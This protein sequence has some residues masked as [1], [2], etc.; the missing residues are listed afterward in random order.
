MFFLE[1]NRRLHRNFMDMIDQQNVLIKIRNEHREYSLFIATMTIFG[2]HNFLS[3][4]LISI[5]LLIF[6][7]YC[8]V[9]L[10]LVIFPSPLKSHLFRNI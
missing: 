10:I 6:H 3:L 2:Y 7:F 5:L 8:F 9:F 4:N 1:T